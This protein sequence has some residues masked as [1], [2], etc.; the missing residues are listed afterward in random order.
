MT[1]KTP[2]QVGYTHVQQTFGPV[3]R[4]MFVRYA[5]ASGDFNPVHYDEPFAHA[6]GF[7][8]PFAPG[9]FP[10]A[11]LA[12]YATNW[13]GAGNV[14]RFKVR[15]REQVWPGDVLTCSGRVSKVSDVDSDSIGTVDLTCTR[16]DDAVVVTGT[17]DF[18]LGSE[19][20]LTMDRDSLR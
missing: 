6:A 15:F 5:G 10:A 12:T 9:M 1:V 14:R 13:L 7:P 16:Q 2:L 20:D 4:E 11:L 18:V 3:T 8:S 17:A 19:I